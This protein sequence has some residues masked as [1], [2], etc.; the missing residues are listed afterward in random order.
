MEC[1]KSIQFIE[2]KKRKEKKR[3]HFAVRQRTWDMSSTVGRPC[4]VH[5]I[6]N[7]ILQKPKR[8]VRFVPFPFF[9]PCSRVRSSRRMSGSNLVMGRWC[10]RLPPT[11][12]TGCH[13]R[14]WQLLWAF[15]IFRRGTVSSPFEVRTVHT[16][17][18]SISKKREQHSAEGQD[19]VIRHSSMRC[20]RDWLVAQQQQL[21]IRPSSL[22][23]GIE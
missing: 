3:K 7:P 22:Y 9:L 13:R 20:T 6:Y 10:I 1:V 15:V 23:A 21:T 2:E 18:Y 5:I 4:C 8:G 16:L 19:V 12:I 17:S 14:W 11:S